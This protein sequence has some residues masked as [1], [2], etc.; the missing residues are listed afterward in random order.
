MS[1]RRMLSARRKD[2]Q[3]WQ[4]LEVNGKSAIAE[5]RED[6]REQVGAEDRSR[7]RSRWT[8]S[9]RSS[10][11]RASRHQRHPARRPATESQS[12]T[13][14]G[15]RR[16]GR[17]SPPDCQPRRGLR[18]P[19]RCRSS[20]SSSIAF[21]TEAEVGAEY[22]GKVVNITKFGAFV[23]ILPGRDGLLHI[24]RL[25]GSKRV[26]RV[27]DYLEDGQEVRVRVREIDR[28]KVSLEL[29]EALDGATLPSSEPAGKGS[30]GSGRRDDRGGRGRGGNRDRDRDRDRRGGKDQN[31]Q[32][33][34]R[35]SESSSDGGR[36]A[37]PS[38]E[39]SF[40]QSRN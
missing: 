33:E 14:D 8:R 9:V 3:V 12:S 22:D 35:P 25:D 40:E 29:V 24:S 17:R 20:V 37:A 38:F 39:E 21:P 23:N 1:W 26:E 27:E 6:V 30:G 4:I 11:P 7:S 15:D 5:P 16:H 18:G 32:R 28:G 36:R 2:A 13:I 31:K 19:E 10:V 34:D